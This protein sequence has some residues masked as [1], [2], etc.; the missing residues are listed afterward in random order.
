MRIRSI[1]LGLGAI[2]LAAPAGAAE[3]YT[4]TG[5]LTGFQTTYTCDAGI[6]SMGGG[7]SDGCPILSSFEE[8]FA[9]FL[10][11]DLSPGVNDFYSGN[12]RGGYGGWHGTIVNNGDTLTGLDLTFG[13]TTC[14]LGPFTAGCFGRTGTAPTF[15]VHTGAVPEPS[16][17]LFMLLGFALVGAIIRR[18]KAASAFHP[19]HT[20]APPKKK[21]PVKAP[22]FSLVSEG[23]WSRGG[24]NP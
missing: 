1:L 15:N 16:T 10:Y 23:W 2:C 9:L 4:L 19:K 12:P 14:S 6:P 18:A 7:L 22:L 11:L 17:W 5:T 8:D 13:Q 21:A 3:I 20:L 24:S